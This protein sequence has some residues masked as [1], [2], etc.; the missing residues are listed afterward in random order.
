MRCLFAAVSLLALGA[1]LPLQTYYRTGAS[2]ERLKTDQ[3]GCEVQALKD[4]PVATQTRLTPPRY[5]PPRSYCDANGACVTKGGVWIGGD[6]YTVDVN[7]DLRRRVEL[8]CMGRLGY[9]P[10]RIP[11]CPPDVARAAPAKATTVLPQLGAKSCAIRNRDG[12]FQI[13]TRG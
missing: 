2:L 3:L 6:V 13:V 9:E 8:Q 7:A 10:A 12:S 11:A 4:A 5:V 1:C